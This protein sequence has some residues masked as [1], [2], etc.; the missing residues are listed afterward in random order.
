MTNI[1]TTPFR[2]S[3]SILAAWER[4]DW[5]DAIDMYFKRE[6]EETEAMRYGKEKHAEWEAEVKAGHMPKVFGG[7][8]LTKP[9]HAELK[10]EVQLADWLVLVG[11][12]DNIEGEVGRDWKTGV[13]RASALANG[14]QHKVYQLLVQMSSLRSD[15]QLQPLKRFEYHVFNQHARTVEMSIVHL[16][17]KSLEEGVEFVTTNASE[18]KNYIDINQL[19]G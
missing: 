19:K 12:L 14:Y 15:I 13:A 16:T 9:Y 18:M 11:V 17:D 4:G 2:A 7:R 1:T 6:R 3:Y 5:D 8:K 10:L